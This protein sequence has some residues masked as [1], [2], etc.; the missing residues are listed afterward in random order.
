M[1]SFVSQ[2][3]GQA[4]FKL[5]DFNGSRRKH[6]NLKE[7]LQ[8][9]KC[10]SSI[11][12]RGLPD[13]EED[14]W[15]REEKRWLREEER[16]LREESRWNTERKA[17]VE[18]H[19]IL[20]QEIVALNAK[21]VQ[22]QNQI[23]SEE[24]N[25]G[26]ISDL[27]VS[28]TQL[29]QS[30]NAVSSVESGVHSTVAQIPPTSSS[31][32]DISILLDDVK[33]EYPKTPVDIKLEETKTPLIESPTLSPKRIET[34]VSV[35][36][37]IS[38][39]PNPS[40]TSLTRSKRI[41]KRGSEGDDV[42]VMQVSYCIYLFRTTIRLILIQDMNEYLFK[43]PQEALEKLGFYSGEEDMEY[44]VFSTGTERAVQTWQV[45]L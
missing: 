10:S 45:S 28:L 27:I 8:I 30:L 14:K 11:A 15:L 32:T 29:L 13:G 5:K 1:F 6:R 22:L 4:A 35:N 39:I 36:S 24:E 40:P 9:R 19:E 31:A 21:I 25:D 18:Q 26:S 17:L 7:S 41:L 42:K 16:W 33:L 2:T 12:V 37:R 34:S 20:K 43:P 23:K 38:E 3:S 44:S